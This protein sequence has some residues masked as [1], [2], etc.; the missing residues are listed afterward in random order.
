MPKRQLDHTDVLIL[1][2]LQREGDISNFALSKRLGIAPSTTLKR[3]ERLKQIGVLG[4]AHFEVNKE[5]L[6]YKE[7]FL[8]RIAIRNERDAIEKLEKT[9]LKDCLV[10]QLWTVAED[11]VIG[12]AQ[13]KALVRAK[14]ESHFKTWCARLLETCHCLLE[15]E[16]ADIVLKSRSELKLSYHDLEMLRKIDNQNS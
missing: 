7:V 16:R 8:L 3:V 5:I 6:G 11:E 9:L 1:N 12:S 2:I 14:D 13:Y 4:T 10:E 15:K